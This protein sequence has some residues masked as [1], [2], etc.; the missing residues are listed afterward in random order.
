MTLQAAGPRALL[1]PKPGW[2]AHLGR[3]PFRVVLSYEEV[4]VIQ[5]RQAAT[6]QDSAFV[7]W[8]DARRAG[9]R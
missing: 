3:Y 5:A 9:T 8:L 2:S 1:D 4:R 7:A 6:G